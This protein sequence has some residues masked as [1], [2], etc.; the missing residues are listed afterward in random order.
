M[1]G[2]GELVTVGGVRY[3]GEWWA[4]QRDGCGVE[5]N[6]TWLTTRYTGMWSQDRITGKYNSKAYQSWVGL[7]FCNSLL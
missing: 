5:H 6:Q 4:G 2:W 1:Q 3:W 7:Q